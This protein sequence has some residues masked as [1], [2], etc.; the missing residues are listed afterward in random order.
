MTRHRKGLRPLSQ[1]G[2][3][4]VPR[5]AKQ[6][7]PD[8]DVKRTVLATFNEGEDTRQLHATK[9]WRGLSVKRAR[10]QMLMAEILNGQGRSL[11][12]QGRFITEGY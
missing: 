6:R 8:T 10:A 4:R 9:G 1:M 5:N 12:V 7:V 2:L 11:L 3:I